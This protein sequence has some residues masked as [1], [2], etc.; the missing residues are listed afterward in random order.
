[1]GLSNVAAFLLHRTQPHDYGRKE[2]VQAV[3]CDVSHGPAEEVALRGPRHGGKVVMREGIADIILEEGH[4]QRIHCRD[5]ERVN[6]GEKDMELPVLTGAD[7]DAGK[8]LLRHIIPQNRFSIN[9][10]SLS[11]CP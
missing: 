5:A 9:L 2:L 3:R 6:S 7:G 11:Y 1:M 10:Q 8:V 4:R